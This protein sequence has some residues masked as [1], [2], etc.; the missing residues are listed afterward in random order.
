V[1][2]SGSVA[3]IVLGHVNGSSTTYAVSID[4]A[5]AVA[6]QLDAT[7]VATHGALGIGGVDTPLG[8]MIAT[9]KADAPA[10]RAGA[11]MH[12]LVQSIDGRA[13]ESIGDVTALVQGFAPGRTVVMALRRG[14]RTLDVRVQLGAT[15]G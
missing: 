7:G 3:G 15:S 13:V 1:N 14:Q 9:M 5:V 12:D 6:R 8:P 4:V 11:H 2:A 10:A